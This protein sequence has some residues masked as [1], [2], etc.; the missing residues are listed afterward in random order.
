MSKTT[1]QNAQPEVKSNCAV[2]VSDYRP[3]NGEGKVAA[4][5]DVEVSLGAEGSLTVYG[6]SV[7]PANSKGPA[8]VGFPQKPS[9]SRWYPVV[10]A[11]GEL[12]RRICAAVLERYEEERQKESVPF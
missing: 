10:E 5:A 7:L 4:Y 2:R 11:D 1:L 9:G 3:T 6:L 12:K 8:W